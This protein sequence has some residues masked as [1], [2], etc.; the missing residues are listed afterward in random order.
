MRRSGL[1]LAVT[2]LSFVIFTSSSLAQVS[3]WSMFQHDRLHTGRTT[4]AGPTQVGTPWTRDLD[5]NT[6]GANNAPVIGNNGAVLIG[7][8]QG[9]VY[10]YTAS[11]TRLW[12]VTLPGGV[13][14]PLAVA[15]NG[16]IIAPTNNDSCYVLD[17]ANGHILWRA[18]IGQANAGAT[19]VGTD[20]FISGNYSGVGFV[21]KLDLLTLNYYWQSS[22][23]W[24]IDRSSPVVM[25]GGQI[26]VGTTEN[27]V[28]YNSSGHVSILDVNGREQCSFDV[29]FFNGR[30]VRSTVSQTSTGRIVGGSVG[31][32]ALYGDGA[33]F[34]P[35]SPVRVVGRARDTTSVHRR[36][37]ATMSLCWARR[38]A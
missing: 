38:T 10:A 3:P 33:F 11:G 28:P 15:A 34:K 6:V 26:A 24:Q 30:G 7:T 35:M 8:V 25:L 20:A 5:G 21:W 14:A 4:V 18:F 27:I 19:I 29:G 13:T 36:S 31:D 32:D 16:R 1:V 37:L 12:K 9:G 2:V 17:P 22:H 23:L